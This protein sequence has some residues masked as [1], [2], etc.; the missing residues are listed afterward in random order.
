MVV[1]LT[2]TIL[3]PATCLVPGRWNSV[4]EAEGVM[5]VLSAVIC[6]G[7]GFRLVLNTSKTKVR[8]PHVAAAV[9]G[10]LPLGVEVCV[11]RRG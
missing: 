11:L 2:G 1:S 10:S 6:E 4:G 8:W 9:S 7:P 5:G 3:E